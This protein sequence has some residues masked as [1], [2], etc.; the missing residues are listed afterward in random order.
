MDS[1]SKIIIQEPLVDVAMGTYNHERF[2]ARSLESV[3]AQETDFPYRIIICDD[4]STD[5]TRSIIMF[6][7]EKYPGKIVT[8]F[9]D[10]HHGLIDKD[11]PYPKVL[12]LCTAKYIA[13]LEGDD[14]W[15]DPHKL[16]KQVD[17]L[18]E[19]PDCTICFHNV[20][21]KDSTGDLKG[22]PTYASRCE[23]LQENIDATFTIRDTLMGGLI[24]T[25]SVLLRNE[26]A[27]Q[28][29]PEFFFDTQTADWLLWLLVCKDKTMRYFHQSMGVYRITSDG[30]SFEIRRNMD[31]LYYNRIQMLMELDSYWGF[32]LH[33]ALTPGIRRYA[34]LT[35]LDLWSDQVLSRFAR[36]SPYAYCWMKLR[37]NILQP[38]FSKL[39]GV[40]RCCGLYGP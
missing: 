7:A 17:Y 8:F 39:N 22:F 10:K 25:C 33:D 37:K 5:N 14:Y 6:Y 26:T 38:L 30:V 24:P 34:K 1:K 13:T 36:Y 4:L 21:Y 32:Q 12:K 18:E 27:I 20:S 28:N 40:L 16:Q 29:L 9:P 23:L 35:P 31:A 2:I 11:R 15:T 19:H 3:L